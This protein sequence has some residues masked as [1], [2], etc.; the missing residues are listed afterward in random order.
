MSADRVGR[1]ALPGALPALADVAPAPPGDEAVLEELRLLANATATGRVA[2]TP[3]PKLPAPPPSPVPEHWSALRHVA[4]RL[5]NED[6]DA[7]ALAVLDDAGRMRLAPRLA[8]VREMAK[9][10]ELLLG[11]R[12][13]A[14][15]T[16]RSGGQG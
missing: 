10:V 7:R 15:A 6:G 11:L 5:S 8:A 14:T 4:S 2:A 1:R 16:L 3:R 13:E 12:N 9:T